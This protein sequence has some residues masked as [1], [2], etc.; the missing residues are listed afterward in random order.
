MLE[1]GNLVGSTIFLLKRND[2]AISENKVF[3]ILS[4]DTVQ[5]SMLVL[6]M[7]ESHHICILYYHF[8]R[9][10]RLKN[11]DRLIKPY[12]YTLYEVNESIGAS[13]QMSA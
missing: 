1:L 3:L 9:T 12:Y 5:C 4:E 6:P 13:L 8:E 10:D 11:L 2:T 7:F